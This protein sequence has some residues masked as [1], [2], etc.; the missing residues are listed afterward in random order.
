MFFSDV[1]DKFKRFISLFQDD[2]LDLQMF[3][4]TISIALNVRRKKSREAI[5]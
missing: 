1:C 4:A 5:L 2:I 3:N